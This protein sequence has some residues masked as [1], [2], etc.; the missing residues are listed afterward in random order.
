MSNKGRRK[1]NTFTVIYRDVEKNIKVL[2]QGSYSK[3]VIVEPINDKS[4]FELEINNPK[5]KPYLKKGKL[6]FMVRGSSKHE[7]GEIKND[8][9]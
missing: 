9:T 3:P 6:S 2:S 5:L 4:D 7:D 1:K 8:V